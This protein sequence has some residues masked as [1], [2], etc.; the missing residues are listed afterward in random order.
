MWAEKFGI[1]ICKFI[2]KHLSIKLFVIRVTM[3]TTMSVVKEIR[4]NKI[5]FF[6]TVLFSL[7]YSVVGVS[8]SIIGPS[9]LDLQIAVSAT[10]NQISYLLPVRAFGYVIGS[11]CGS[12]IPKKSDI[13]IYVVFCTVAVAVTTASLPW[14][15]RILTILVNAGFSGINVLLLQFWGKESAPFIQFL[16]FFYGVGSLVAPLLTEPFLLPVKYDKIGNVTLNHHYK[17]HDLKIRLPYAIIAAYAFSVLVIFIIVYCLKKKYTIHPSLSIEDQTREEKRSFMKTITIVSLPA[18]FLHLYFGN[19]ITFGG[20]L[21]TFSVKS[22][23]NLS[24]SKGAF[25]TSIFWSANALFRLPVMILMR[26]FSSRNLIILELILMLS[27]SAVLSVFGNQYEIALWTSAI[28]MGLGSSS[29][30][31]LYVGYLNNYIKL[32]NKILSILLVSACVG[33]F[34]YPVVIAK[35]IDL[36]A[37]I[38]IYTNSDHF[39]QKKVHLTTKQNTNC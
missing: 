12:F 23:L 5:N 29:I 16:Y 31:A 21:T 24:K 14:N 39:D 25:M 19:T 6:K 34:L 32:T 33:E 2:K 9:L 13:Q 22:K 18:I 3:K 17:P 7:I 1:K 35:Y 28:L 4:N 36:N 30:F 37:N 20:F 15:R 10:I 27:S 26:I 11:L 38:F 8:M